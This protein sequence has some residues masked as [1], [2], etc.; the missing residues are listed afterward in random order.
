MLENNRSKPNKCVDAESYHFMITTKFVDVDGCKVRKCDTNTVAKEKETAPLEISLA[1]ALGL[2]RILGGMATC[3]EFKAS[4]HMSDIQDLPKPD[5]VCDVHCL[6][7]NILCC[8]SWSV[9]DNGRVLRVIPLHH[10]IVTRRELRLLYSSSSN[11]TACS[12]ELTLIEVRAEHVLHV[13]N[14]GQGPCS[15]FVSSYDQRSFL[16][17]VTLNIS[18]S[19]TSEHGKRG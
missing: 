9:E 6:H 11:L 10:R 3:P 19:W 8:L 2:T 7:T 4:T 1:L 18:S 5:R 16:R 15:C 13:Y 12:P 14:L 17:E